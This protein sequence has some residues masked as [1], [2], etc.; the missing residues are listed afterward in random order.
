VLDLGHVA[1][2]SRA[3]FLVSSANQAALAW[4]EAWP[5]WPTQALALAGPPG[6]GKSHLAR[7][8]VERSRAIFVGAAALSGSLALHLSSGQPIVLE[9]GQSHVGDPAYEEALFHLFN[10]L[11]AAGRSLLIVDTEPPARWRIGLKDLASRLATLPVATIEAPDDAL[12]EKLFYKLFADRQLQVAPE[13]V[14]FILPRME[15]SFATV[16]RIVGDLD[17]TALVRKSPIT[18][19]TARTVLAALD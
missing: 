12:L 14:A 6:S 17:R 4:I 7:I 10:A 1:A 18:L 3:D 13:I 15:R 2:S 5:D 19:A 16:H 8:W 11:R 9:G